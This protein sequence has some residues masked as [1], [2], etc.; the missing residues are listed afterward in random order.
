M[1][2]RE[3]KIL[4]WLSPE[5][6]CALFASKGAM[7][8]VNRYIRDTLL[9]SGANPNGSLIAMALFSRFYNRLAKKCSALPGD[10]RDHRLMWVPKTVYELLKALGFCLLQD[11]EGVQTPAL[12]A[13]GRPVCLRMPTFWR[14]K[15]APGT[16][17]RETAPQ[18][19]NVAE[20]KARHSG[21]EPGWQQGR[22]SR[23]VDWNK[24]RIAKAAGAGAQDFSKLQVEANNMEVQ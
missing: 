2:K 8:S 15:A 11:A 12:D 17:V 10:L 16:P 24:R 13:K 9:I 3:D 23:M 19:G 7:E 22:S 6:V 20:N 14:G 21:K 5:D 4:V 18:I 1:R